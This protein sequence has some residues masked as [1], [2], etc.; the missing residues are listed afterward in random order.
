MPGFSDFSTHLALPYIQPAQAQKHITH[1]EGM[2]RLDALVHLSATSMSIA[3]PPSAPNSGTRFI[4]PTGASGA[5]AGQP[6]SIL[7]VFEDTTW[8]F[9]AP[10][11]GWTAWIKDI[12]R[13]QVF[14]G[15]DWQNLTNTP[16]YQNLPQLGVQTT[17]DSINRLAVA[18]TAT[19]LTH[20]G[21]GHQV[22][23]NK[24]AT[25]D[26]ASLLFQTGWSGRAEMG[27]AGSDN[28]EVKVSPDGTT[29]HRALIAD[30]A[31]GRVRF[32]QGADGLAPEGFG[33]GPVLTTD[34]AAARG[35]DLVTNGTGLL[36][37]TYN[38]PPEF[39]YDATT[40]P[41]LP[42][43]F[44]FAG[45]Y[46][47]RVQML[48]PLPIDPNRVYRLE[49]YLRQ[50]RLP[51]DWSAYANGERHSQYMGL[52][53]LDLDDEIIM[54]HHHMRYRK[55]GVDSLTTLTAP[56]A[57]GDTVIHLN[58]TSGWND[59]FTASYYRGLI[60]FGYRNSLGF[61]YDRYSRLVEMDM[62]DIGDVDK[63]THTVT[64]NKPL[65][66]SLANPDDPSGIWPI[67]AEIANASSGSTY[68]Y[69]FYNGLIL[70]E[71][72][73]WYRTESYMGGIDRSGG[74]VLGNFPPGTARARVFWMPNHTNRSGGFSSHPD[75]GPAHRVWFSGVSVT[76]E[77]LAL[78]QATAS[79]AQS[80][81]VPQGDFAA[82]TLALA[83]A[84][85]VVEPI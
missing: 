36:G 76:P 37:N 64:L 57:P 22:K 11:P 20:A 7:A 13:H 84:S 5:W 44:S 17:A 49:S 18:G 73:R 42:A 78:T 6:A 12:A 46:N 24:A 32:P 30:A 58:D 69:A 8:I 77:T 41:N 51:G 26:T 83:P 50:E 25:A 60:M 28:F 70:S 74:N 35:T 72:D 79:G 29:F 48:E 54:A 40:A 33:T 66:V 43:S 67:G 55:G 39:S 82:G 16:D 23:I 53:C 75:T 21:A 65:P 71:T 14:D 56:L 63:T 19:L 15:S 27:I 68:K 3:T 2:R 31:T 52:I 47:N 45:Y 4:L 10:Q 38:Y 81:K 34:Y 85:S 59:T 62:F 80:I 61:T 1:N 9:Y